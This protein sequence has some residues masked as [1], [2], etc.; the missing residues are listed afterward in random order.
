[1]GLCSSSE[2]VSASRAIDTVQEQ[3]KKVNRAVTKLLLLGAGESGKSTLFK[4]LKSI[5]GSGFTPEDRVFF[6]KAV[7]SNI[8]SMMKI[9]VRQSELLTP[10]SPECKCALAD[11]GAKLTQYDE[12][13]PPTGE[14]F[15]WVKDLW[16]DAGIRATWTK[17]SAFQLNDMVHYFFDKIDDISKPNY[18]PTDAD[19]YRARVRTTGI[20]EYKFVHKDHIFRIFD[21]GGQRNERRKWIHCFENVTAV[22]FFAALSE[23]D[24]KL[25]EEE[26][27]NR[28]L[29]AL[30][31]FEYVCNCQWFKK[32]ST[33]LF[34][35]KN[36][37]FQEK[38]KKVDMKC[39]FPEYSGGC[40]YDNALNYIKEQFLARCHDS[41]KQIFTHVT[42]CTDTGA[43]KVVFSA[44]AD[45][46]IRKQLEITGM[47]V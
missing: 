30:N 41:E 3:E 47:L 46:I 45:T 6:R 43:I 29:E 1:M 13:E 26:T 15:K 19:I 36:D 33:V 22:I 16:A 35:N 12:L 31:L 14:H 39:C 42:C 28:M 8:F 37:L 23:Y 44:V 25:Y 24:Q 5:Y 4:Q 18:S 32:T 7:F 9:L 11:V 38:I 34:L 20:S 21:V 27:E 10:T 2:E 40:N 17:R